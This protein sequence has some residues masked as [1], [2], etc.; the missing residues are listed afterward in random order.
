MDRAPSTGCRARLAAGLSIAL[1]MAAPGP[2]LGPARAQLPGPESFAKRPET[3]L[4]LWDAVDYLVRTGQAERAVPYLDAFLKAN[5]DDATLL[6]IRDRYGLG[7]VLRLGDF[8]ATRPKAKPVLDL[9]AAATRRHAADPERLQRSIAA[10]TATPEEQDLAVERLREAGPFAVPPLVHVLSDP[11]LS[12]DDRAKIVRNMGRLGRSAVPALL[13]ALEAPDAT[14]AADIADALGH[15]GDPRAIPNLT[16]YAARSGGP[17]PLRDAARRALERLT[18]RS[19]ASQP[20]APVRVLA[21][22]ARKYLLGK[23]NFPDGPFEVWIWQESAPAPVRMDRA[24]AETLFGSRFARW[25]LELEPSDRDAQATLVGIVLKAALHQPNGLAPDDPTGAFAQAMATGPSVLRDVLRRALADGQSELAALAAATLGRVADRDALAKEGLINPLVAA[26]TAPDRRVRFAGARALVEL[27]PMKPFAGS[28]RVVPVLAQFVA[29]EPTPKAVIIDGNTARA[30]AVAAV[31]RSLGYEALRASSGDWGFRQ[32]AASADVELV[33]IEPSALE[34]AWTLA[35]TLRNLRADARTTGLPIF[36]LLP[37]DI[38]AAMI[39]AEQVRT[40]M[41]ETEPNDT[42]ALSNLLAFTAPP[43]RARV[44]GLLAEG[45]VT[46]DYFRIGPLAAG[47]AIS[48]VVAVPSFSTLRLADVRLSIERRNEGTSPP[49]GTVIASDTGAVG[50]RIGSDGEYYLHVEGLRH[51]GPQARY[52]VDIALVE[53]VPPPFGP[54]ATRYPLENIAASY[55][56]VAVVAVPTDP[57]LL[58]QQLER[59]LERMGARPLTDAERAA[60]AREAAALLAQI[61]ARPGSPFEPDLPAAG[62]ALEVALNHPE[63]GPAAALAL[64]DVP[65]IDAQR[66]L[67]D[68]LLDPGKAPPLRLVAADQLARSIQRFGPLLSADQEV[69]LQA[70]LDSAADPM[71]RAALARVYGALRPPSD[72][73]GRRLRAYDVTSPAPP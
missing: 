44:S 38:G 25:A 21:A 46:G 18:G 56:Q 70:E 19:F 22:E 40:P 31:L 67:A 36:L 6:E 66:G 58:R 61:A 72:A 37:V 10:L 5:P 7:S 68:A 45:D 48:A 13:A 33:L 43:R 47:T 23:V 65:R 16:Y 1:I 63:T 73:V 28:S 4:E 8:P 24:A 20:Q 12:L 14:V 27:A 3:P 59:G 30:N 62:P 55:P 9:I 2:M 34:G 41:A 17:S 11:S 64:G 60:Y 39:R 49:V 51:R 57:G 26:L 54:A 71:L 42:L 29:T 35:D 15:I 53:L 69:R 32:A 50:V 52:E